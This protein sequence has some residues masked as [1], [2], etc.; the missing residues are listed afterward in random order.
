LRAVHT[1]F[2]VVLC[3]D[4]IREIVSALRVIFDL[5]A[6]FGGGLVRRETAAVV[7]VNSVSV[8][9]DVG[10]ETHAYAL[11]NV[12]FEVALRHFFDN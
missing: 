9:V 2:L 11:L 6:T 5:S 4:R 1:Y 12:A 8:W 7:F 3:D 10:N